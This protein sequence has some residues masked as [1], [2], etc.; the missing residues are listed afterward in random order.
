MSL[1]VLC[2]YSSR[3]CIAGTFA[4][5]TGLLTVIVTFNNPHSTTTWPTLQ[6][7]MCYS[8]FLTFQSHS[9][10]SRREE[11]AFGQAK[12]RLQTAGARKRKGGSTQ[13]RGTAFEHLGRCTK[14]FCPY[15]AQRGIPWET[16]NM[17]VLHKIVR[18][19]PNM[20]KTLKSQK[21]RRKSCRSW[22]LLPLSLMGSCRQHYYV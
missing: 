4:A 11:W 13:L 3:F 16:T 20:G 12:S 19:V 21:P 10:E 2:V 22:V 6:V 17:L 14:S 9:Y 8:T 7:T 5:I 18:A 15:K 1:L